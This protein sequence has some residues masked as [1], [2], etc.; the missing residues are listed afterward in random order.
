[1]SK[2]VPM[3]NPFFPILFSMHLTTLCS[4]VSMDDPIL[5]PNCLSLESSDIFRSKSMYLLT[6]FS[7][8]SCIFL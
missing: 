1:M 4:A 8:F 5:N 3:T 7:E 6:H 2:K